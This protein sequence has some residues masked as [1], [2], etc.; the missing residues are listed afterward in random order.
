MLRRDDPHFKRFGEV[1]FSVVKPGFV[2]GWHLHKKMTLNYAV[3]EG[4]VHLCLFDAREGSRTKG[5]FQE[6]SLGLD[7]YSLVTVP[8]GVWNGFEAEG[9]REAIV[10]NCSDEPHEAAEI[11][12]EDPFVSS[13][14]NS[15]RAKVG[16]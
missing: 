7:N 8:P 5:E 1:Y 9:E 11:V 10:A 3:V 6:L 4:R 15:W 13:I 12:R 16:R 2:K 14:P